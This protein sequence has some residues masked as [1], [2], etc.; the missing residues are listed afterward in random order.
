MRVKT[1]GND[2]ASFVISATGVTLG[3]VNA[4]DGSV[5]EWY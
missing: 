1:K 3:A 5:G 4:V 2:T